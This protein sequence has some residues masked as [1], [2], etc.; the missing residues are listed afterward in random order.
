M[1]MYAYVC[2]LRFTTFPICTYRAVT[3]LRLLSMWLPHIAHS[4]YDPRASIPHSTYSSKHLNIS[5]IEWQFPV[6][7][8]HLSTKID[9]KNWNKHPKHQ[10]LRI[11]MF[12]PLSLDF[13]H[14][15]R[16]SIVLLPHTWQKNPLLTVVSTG[17]FSRRILN[18]PIISIAPV[19]LSSVAGWYPEIC[20]TDQPAANPQKLDTT[21]HPWQW[22]SALKYWLALV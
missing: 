18:I 13:S 3:L 5:F 7:H 20:G 14:L 19:S 12:P 22:Y 15:A 9:P 16:C 1:C 21:R 2:I 11:S 10:N 8:E 17:F 6:L 4:K